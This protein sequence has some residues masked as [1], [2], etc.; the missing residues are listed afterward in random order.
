MDAQR[1]LK[2]AEARPSRLVC[3][4]VCVC[5]GG[6]GLSYSTLLTVPYSAV[7]YIILPLQ[8]THTECIY[9]DV[10]VSGLHSSQP[11]L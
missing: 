8:V 7:L 9:A 5:V 4:F 6:H 3:V 11:H 1:K 10:D 2:L